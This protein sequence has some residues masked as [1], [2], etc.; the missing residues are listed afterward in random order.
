MLYQSLGK[1][2][3]FFIT[4]IE[5]NNKL[6][7]LLTLIDDINSSV[8]NA[9]T[10]NVPYVALAYLYAATRTI[11]I[12]SR[13]WFWDSEKACCTDAIERIKYVSLLSILLFKR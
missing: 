9:V 13:L 8:N 4:N 2:L 10:T 7:F 1:L 11:C 3:V 5:I 12:N 6:P